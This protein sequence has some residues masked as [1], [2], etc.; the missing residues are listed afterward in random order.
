MPAPGSYFYS[1]AALVAAQTALLG[2]ID[3][4]AAAGKL[5]L[6]SEADVLLA[7]ITLSDPAGTVDG[8][9]QLTITAPAAATA[10][11]T[12]TCTYGTVTD[13]A[14]TVILTA[15]VSQGASAVSGQIVL[16]NTAIV[17]GADVT[18]VSFTIG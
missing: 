13:G 2:E 10:V 11:A 4:D 9:G 1:A 18:L 3:A 7:T 17:T 15:P 8:A 16:S 12:D 5:K 14:D 6:Y